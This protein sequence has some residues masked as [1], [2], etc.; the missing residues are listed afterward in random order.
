MLDLYRIYV[1]F[2]VVCE[3]VFNLLIKLW[4]KWM[5]FLMKVDKASFDGFDSCVKKYFEKKER[6]K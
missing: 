4:L 2:G 5:N 6:E 1:I 3:L